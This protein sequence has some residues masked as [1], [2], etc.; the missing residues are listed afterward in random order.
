M[1]A[2]QQAAVQLPE[3][4]SSLFL[5][6]S[7]QV[8]AAV[9]E[10]RLR[11]GCPA[12]LTCGGESR[13]LTQDG[14]MHSC[15]SPGLV[16]ITHRELQACFL[17]LC[18]Y[19]VFAYENQLRR[20][21]FTLR[22][23]HRVGVAAPAVWEAERL[24]QPRSVTS[25]VVRIAR[26]IPLRDEPRWK[27][28]LQEKYPRILIAGAPGSGKTTVLRAL[29]RLLS[30][31]GL[32]VAAA[33]ERCELFPLD[34]D[35]FVFEQ[36]WNCDVLS[37]LPKADAME[38]A[39]RALSPQVLL[40]DELGGGEAELL[41]QSLNSG[42]GFVATVHA[43]DKKELLAKPQVKTLLAASAVRRVVLLDGILPGGVGECFD[44][45]T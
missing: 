38:Q 24:Q 20:G 33:D 44:V 2:Y 31:G 15:A 17:H 37:G 19:S 43:A 25:L 41:L 14:I 40:C 21:F 45:D 4:W 22:G 30:A 27:A 3:P 36:P 42:V 28:I 26:D 7:P 9:T 5:R 39:L 23:G 12:A 16:R 34:E 13:F 8:Q 18:R 11:S 10:L 6:V 1:K 35:G 29:T 32:R